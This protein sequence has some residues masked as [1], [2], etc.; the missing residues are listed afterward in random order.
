MYHMKI[1][2]SLISSLAF[3]LLMTSINVVASRYLSEEISIREQ[4]EEWMVQYG[5]AKIFKN[6]QQNVERIEALRKLN[7]GYEVGINNF[8]DMT[9]EEFEAAYTD[10]GVVSDLAPT[11]FTFVNMSYP[12]SFDWR[13]LG[14]VTEVKD[15][16]LNSGDLRSLSEQQIIDCDIYDNGCNGGLAARVYKYA[17]SSTGGK[18]VGIANEEEYPYLDKTGTCKGNS[19]G[20]DPVTIVGGYEFVPSN[21]EIDLARAVAQGSVSVRVQSGDG[22]QAYTGG[23]FKGPCGKKLNHAMTIVGYTPSYWI[24]KNWGVWWGENGY[25]RMRRGADGPAGLC[26]IAREPSYPFSYIERNDSSK[27]NQQNYH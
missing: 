2:N 15:Q 5:R 6:F 22:L 4:F 9:Q 19:I 1:N 14:A 11:P 18:H 24:V 8:S 3:L 23:I 17:S 27:E 16:G 20:A 12:D 21:S 26:G 7:L 10:G 25:I 13:E